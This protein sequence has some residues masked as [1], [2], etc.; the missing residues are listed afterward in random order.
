MKSLLL[1]LMVLL[2]L[3]ASARA[4]ELFTLSLDEH[5]SLGTVIQ[6]DTSVKR[7]GK[8]AVRITTS[9]P[10]TICLG[11]I[12]A[13]GV[14]NSRLLYQAKV[15]SQDLQGTAFLEMWCQV[16]GTQYFSRGMD[17]V[18]TG[19]MDWKT[20]ETP[21]LLQSGQKAETLTLNLVVNGKGT[22][23]VDDVRVLKR[24]RE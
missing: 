4:E 23:W 14:E 1:T 6:T 24:L 8:G 18:V 20:L 9:W 10:T 5:G 11:V 7:E 17:S 19:D 3:G 21:F 15:K 16:A 22:V 13:L 12:P 2:L